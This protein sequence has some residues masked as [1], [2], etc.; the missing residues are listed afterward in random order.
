MKPKHLSK[1][2]E[3]ILDKGP[4]TVKVKFECTGVHEN[5]KDETRYLVFKLIGLKKV[6]T[7]VVIFH[8]TIFKN[9]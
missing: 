8:W 6:T 5:L 1:K 7:R 4:M 9:V 2:Q 3:E